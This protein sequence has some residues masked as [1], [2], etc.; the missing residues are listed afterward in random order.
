MTF[1]IPSCWNHISKKDIALCPG[2]VLNQPVTNKSTSRDVVW[3]FLTSH[4]FF[5][6][7]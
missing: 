4:F 5:Y 7:I 3:A 2:L 6:R 1:Q